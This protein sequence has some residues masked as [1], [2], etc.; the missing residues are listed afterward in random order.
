M[1]NEEIWRKR[2]IAALS[3]ALVQKNIYDNIHNVLKRQGFDESSQ[4]FF[5]NVNKEVFT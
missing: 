4:P 1:K 2:V 5:N 3:C